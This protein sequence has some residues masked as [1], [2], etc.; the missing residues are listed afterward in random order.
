MASIFEGLRSKFNRNSLSNSEEIR[1][2]HADVGDATRLS[3]YDV[4]KIISE[5]RDTNNNYKDRYQE[6]YEMSRDDVIGSALEIFADDSTQM[7]TDTSRR[8]T[9]VCKKTNL[10]KD[11]EAFLESM[12]IDSRLWSWAYDT[13][14]YGDKFVKIIRDKKGNILYLE[15]V[16]DPS[17]IMDLHYLGMRVNFAREVPS[18]ERN[19][20]SRSTKDEYEFYGKDEYVH[21]MIPS[22]EKSDK[23]YVEVTDPKTGQ[24]DTR[25]Y[26]VIRGISIIDKARESHRILSLLEDSMLAARIAKAEYFRIYNIEVGETSNPAQSRKL[27]TKVKNMFDSKPRMNTN[28]GSYT[29]YKSLRPI[30]DPIFNPVRGGKGSIEHTEVGG[31]FEVKSLVDIDYFKDKKFSALKVPKVMLGFDDGN[32]MGGNLGDTTATLQDMRY[33]RSVKK[34]SSA[35]AHGVKDIVNLWLKSLGRHADVDQFEIVLTSPSSSEEIMRLKE[36]ELRLDTVSKVVDLSRDFNEHVDLP[37]LTSEVLDLLSSYPELHDVLKSKYSEASD[38]WRKANDA[39]LDDTMSSDLSDDEVLDRVL[40]NPD[41]LD[42][43]KSE[44]SGQSNEL[45]DT[46]TTEE[47]ESVT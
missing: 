18:E 12:N 20:H 7:D 27:I 47:G 38:K 23:F 2:K 36:L 24:L 46:E 1:S 28:T 13:A 15:D 37:G 44:L 11:I 29:S 17:E 34:V 10:R 30:G 22:S 6:Y 40:S 4:Y 43:L 41:L 21:F 26:Q 3:D 45:D 5:L 8:I 14:T 9:V 31:D 25:K 33:A 32:L 39:M 16:G 42:K 19:K 35:V